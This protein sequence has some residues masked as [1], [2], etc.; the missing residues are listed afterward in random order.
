MMIGM[1]RAPRWFGIV[2]AVLLLW[3]LLGCFSCIQQLRL[4]ADAM[5][6]ASDYDRALYASLPGW[7]NPCFVV[8]VLSGTIGA[9]ALLARSRAAVWL[10][11]LALVTVIVMFGY[12]FVATDLIAHKGVMLATGFPVVVAAIAAFQLWLARHARAAGWIG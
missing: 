10:A 2:A 12:M 7:Y 1:V 11:V 9:A 6:P 4:G 8:A 5:G 3:G